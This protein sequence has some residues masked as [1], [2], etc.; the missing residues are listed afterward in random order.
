MSKQIR[1]GIAR[2]SHRWVREH[3]SPSIQVFS[4]AGRK[5]FRTM[6]NEWILHRKKKLRLSYSVLSAPSDWRRRRVIRA[7][8]QQGPVV[9]KKRQLCSA[10]NAEEARKEMQVT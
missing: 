5:K 10:Q 4:S 9:R 2:G 1:Q 8:S 6:D 3:F 7:A